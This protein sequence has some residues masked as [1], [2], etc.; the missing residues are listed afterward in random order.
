MSKKRNTKR[1]KDRRLKK[2]S[3]LLKKVID[4]Q[5]EDVNEGDIPEGVASA[6]KN[7]DD[8][9]IYSISFAYYMEN[10]CELLKM[11]GNKDR[12]T[13]YALCILKDIGFFANSLNKL[14][15]EKGYIFKPVKN[16]GQYK[17]L[18]NGLKNRLVD[19]K[20]TVVY[21]AYIKN[22]EDGRMFFWILPDKMIIYILVIRKNHY[23]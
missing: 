12:D 15:S 11:I 1:K 7:I 17:K 8:G 10:E 9:E 16:G 5:K 6:N 4:R 20:D 14:Q 19:I 3:L 23:K 22:R 21:E 18:Y 2:K 13:G